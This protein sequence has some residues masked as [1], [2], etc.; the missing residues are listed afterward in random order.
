MNSVSTLL[1][2]KDFFRIVDATIDFKSEKV[3]E[4]CDQLNMTVDGNIFLREL[5][6][7]ISPY[8]TIFSLFIEIQ[9][10]QGKT[11]LKMDDE[12]VLRVITPWIDDPDLSPPILNENEYNDFRTLTNFF[13]TSDS[14]IN[15]E[16]IYPYLDELSRKGALVETS[17]QITVDK[18]NLVHGLNLSSQYRCVIY[19]SSEKL[20]SSIKTFDVQNLQ[21]IFAPNSEKKIIVLL[22][23]VIG[24]A[25]GPNLEI[26]GFDRWETDFLSAIQQ[27]DKFGDRVANSFA[28]RETDSSWNFTPPNLTP[29]HFAL[30]KSDIKLSPLCNLFNKLCDYFCV[31]FLANKVSQSDS[32]ILAEFFGY[33]HVQIQL[34]NIVIPENKNEVYSLFQ[35]AYENSSSDKLEIIRHIISLQLSKN[36]SENFELLMCHA[37]Q[38][39][40][41]SKGNFNYVIKKSVEQYFE[42]RL[43]LCEYLQKINETINE[44]ISEFSTEMVNNLYKTIGVV[45]GVI[46]TALINPYSVS[47]IIFWASTLY[48]IYIVFIMVYALPHIYY[49]FGSELDGYNQNVDV[50]K[51]VL[52]DDEIRKIEGTRYKKNRF[53]FLLFF[54]FTNLGYALLGVIAFVFARVTK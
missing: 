7:K 36:P 25:K 48:I 41:I 43:K 40:E 45:L 29:Y 20:T 53:R 54:G 12:G 11:T 44:N 5:V 35:W 16:V 52:L 24:I 8:K 19:L 47:K 6:P 50:L 28:I 22:A 13:E 39:L 49:K 38:I 42:K 26:I 15:P 18:I 17:I 1:N 3:S 27:E 30:L 34:P 9:I 37:S 2:L 14:E 4:N 46:L 33:Q 32:G 31:L 21:K 10:Q 51:D 23:D